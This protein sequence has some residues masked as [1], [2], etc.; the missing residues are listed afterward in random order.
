M[1]GLCGWIGRGSHGRG[2][3]PR[4]IVERM[5]ARLVG[6]EPGRPFIFATD[7]GALHGDCSGMNDAWRTESGLVAAIQGQPRWTDRELERIAA[8][9]GHA[10]ALAEA[11]RRSGPDL[12]RQLHGAFTFAVIDPQTETALLAIDRSG[13]MTLCFAQPDPGRLVFATT[14]DSVR[15]HPGIGATVAPQKIFD[16]LFFV[17][18]I[19]A[20]HTIYEEQEKLLPG[21]YLVFERGKLERRRYWEVP[22]SDDRNASLDD[23]AIELHQRLR[24]AVERSAE[25][26]PGREVGAF[27]SGGLDSS[28]VAGLL[29]GTT[30]KPI[31]SFTI[32]FDIGEF[33]ESEYA[34]IA[35]RHFGLDHHQYTM[36][37]ADVF[38]A[39]P[40]IARIYDEP[41]ANSSAVPT[42][43]CAKRA[44]EAG[45]G[46]LVAGDGGDEV[47]AGNS[48]Y[49]QDRIFDLYGRMPEF[50]HRRLVEP[51]ISS[52]PFERIAPLRRAR[53]YL[54]QAQ[55]TPPHRALAYNVY[56]HAAPETVF[57]PDAIGEIDPLEPVRFLTQAYEAPA[58]RSRLKR[59]LGVDLRITLADS[60]LRKVNRMCEAA[61]VQVAYPFLDDDVVEFSARVPDHML[62]RH[63]ELRYFYKQAMRG[64][65]PP[66][67]ISKPKHGFGL[68]FVEYAS[69]HRPLRELAFDSLMALKNRHYFSPGWI[70]GF[71]GPHRQAEFERYGGIAWDLMMLEL[72]FQHHLDRELEPA[73]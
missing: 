10:H 62:I 52:P 4:S 46:V 40:M 33:D 42:Y 47:F 12:L 54:R 8:R 7:A 23:L 11:Y 28:T 61:G 35:A 55:M 65:L 58:T 29:A 31:K 1:S 38:D 56:R 37:P 63:G 25:I 34:R 60:D 43:I 68:P 45:V 27:L 3:P 53:N 5:A 71:L 21:H 64:F 51:L 59:T 22:Y 16:Y 70:D 49:L 36:S 24:I 57:S 19:P 50:A 32:G 20:P 48:R 17:D 73:L 6:A 39:I 2:E 30:K 69:R 44:S 9:H 18:R 26:G 67:I 15:G 13:I 14:T 72:W 66:E 41:F